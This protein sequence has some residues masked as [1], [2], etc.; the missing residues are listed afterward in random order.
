[1]PSYWITANSPGEIAGWLRPVAARLKER[2]PDLSIK[3]VLLPCTFASGHEEEVARQVPAVDDVYRLGSLPKDDRPEGLLHLGGD[4]M[5]AAYLARQYKMPAW[6]YQWAQKQ[7]DRNFQG[8][9]V[10]TDRDRDRLLKQGIGGS[11]IRVVG[12]LVVDAVWDD[13]GDAPLAD[14]SLPQK[15]LFMPGSRER[16]AQFLLPFYLRVAG[17]VAERWPDMT[18]HAMLSPFLA[19]L[20][21]R[22]EPRPRLG[23]VAGTVERDRLLGE[24]GTTI[25]LERHS[26]AHVGD[27][28]MVVSIPGTKTA[29]ASVLG[30][31]LV[32]VL[33]L[34]LPEEIPSIGLVG[35]LDWVPGFGRFVK[36]FFLP[37]MVS[38]MGY[39]AQPNILAGREMVPEIK[40]VITPEAVGERV[41]GLLAEKQTM[42]TMAVDLRTLYEPFR[43]ASVRLVD[44]LCEDISARISPRHEA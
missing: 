17:M 16:E 10:K 5:Y 7:W 18:F 29:E 39:V 14:R 41:L 13:L 27:A 37:K 38:R 25:E 32:V 15:L 23:G 43:G 35:L 36:G 19:P 40:G 28:D 31:P 1:M 44:V 26:M 2:R 30:R 22:L 3:V 12:D 4:L 11:R 20:Q 8:Y 34:N 33:P 6:A 42:S 21:G 24:N 9:L